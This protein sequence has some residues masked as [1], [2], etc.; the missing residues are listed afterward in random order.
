MILRLLLCKYKRTE[1][2]DV[3]TSLLVIS[4]RVNDP[5]KQMILVNSKFV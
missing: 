1:I 4:F 3:N 5:S 2:K